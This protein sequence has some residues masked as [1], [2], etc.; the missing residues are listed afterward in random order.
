MQLYVL[1]NRKNMNQKSARQEDFHSTFSHERRHLLIH[2]RDCGIVGHLVL[3]HIV[4]LHSCY[5]TLPLL[6]WWRQAEERAELVYLSSRV[7]QNISEFQLQFQN[8]RTRNWKKLPTWFI[9][10]RVFDEWEAAVT[11]VLSACFISGL[12]GPLSLAIVH[13]RPF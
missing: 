7:L 12:F 13:F 6:G 4:K 10:W 1:Q 2:K 3:F 8:T 9:N 5:N 11:V